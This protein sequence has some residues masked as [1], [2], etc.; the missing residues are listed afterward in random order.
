MTKIHFL[1][2][3]TLLHNQEKKVER[4]NSYT[5]KTTFNWYFF[6]HISWFIETS[7]KPVALCTVLATRCGYSWSQEDE[8]WSWHTDHLC[9]ANETVNLDLTRTSS[10]FFTFSCFISSLSLWSSL[11]SPLVLFLFLFFLNSS[12]LCQL[13]YFHCL[14]QCS[15]FPQPFITQSHCLWKS[16]SVWTHIAE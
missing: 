12:N 16:F 14:R 15:M 8:S 2:W 3:I 11:I 9:V 6:P 13:V 5:F 1:P 10:C 7:W 4:S